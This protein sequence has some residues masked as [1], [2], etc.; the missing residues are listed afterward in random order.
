LFPKEKDEASRGKTGGRGGT[1]KKRGGLEK[2]TALMLP[3]RGSGHGPTSAWKKVALLPGK[4]PLCANQSDLS[5]NARKKKKEVPRLVTE[6]RR[7]GK[8]TKFPQSKEVMILT[9]RGK[10]AGKEREGWTLP[11]A[12][13][14]EKG[15]HRGTTILTVSEGR[16]VALSRKDATWG[17]QE[18]SLC[19][20]KKKKIAGTTRLAGRRG[21]PRGEGRTKKDG[22]SSVS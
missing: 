22:K 12:R 7:R 3:K 20:P 19:R 9:N 15:V 17:R 10:S 16:K 2:D 18:Y 13:R 11:F 4:T 8:A 1:W 5:L 21:V 6:W 14:G